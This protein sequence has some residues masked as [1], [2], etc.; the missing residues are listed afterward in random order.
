MRFG[1][2]ECRACPGRRGGAGGAR[3]RT[4][5]SGVGFFVGVEVA[6]EGDVFDFEFVVALFEF[7]DRGD[8]GP[9]GQRDKIG[10]LPISCFFATVQ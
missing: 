9:E 7:L 5:W 4:R 1:Q 10:D 2:G 6:A 8:H 3:M